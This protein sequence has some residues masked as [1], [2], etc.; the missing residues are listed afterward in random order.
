MKKSLGFPVLLASTSIA[1]AAPMDDKIAEAQ[2][3]GMQQDYECSFGIL[4]DLAES[5]NML[6]ADNAVGVE[7]LTGAMLESSLISAANDW[8]AAETRLA[9]ERYLAVVTKAHPD[10]GIFYA[11]GHALRAISCGE[12]GAVACRKDSVSYLC[13]NMGRL[14]TPMRGH[15]AYQD[16]TNQVMQL[17]QECEGSS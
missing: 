8:S 9:A 6:L 14:N 12:L 13:T 2:Q 11:T 15:R 16:F 4:I 5:E 17:M 7:F 1:F 3:C 10:L